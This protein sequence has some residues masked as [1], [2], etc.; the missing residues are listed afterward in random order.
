MLNVNSNVI[1]LLIKSKWLCTIK[2]CLVTSNSSN[3]H[4]TYKKKKCSRVQYTTKFTSRRSKIL[5]LSKMYVLFDTELFFEF[6][7]TDKIHL[8]LNMF[9]KSSCLGYPLLVCISH[10]TITNVSIYFFLS[11]KIEVLQMSDI[12]LCN[13]GC[14]KF[15]KLE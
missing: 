1:N 14:W 8:C 13:R 2:Y 6:L 10:N 7:K 11:I 12:F 5:Y 15:K 9:L 3:R 4:Y